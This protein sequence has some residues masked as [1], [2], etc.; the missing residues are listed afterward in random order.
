MGYIIRQKLQQKFGLQQIFMVD[1]I[2]VDAVIGENKRTL[3]H[4]IFQVE[5]IYRRFEMIDKK[6]NPFNLTMYSL[7]LVSIKIG[8]LYISVSVYV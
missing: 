2:P 4:Y 3:L 1:E 6:I 7:L 5:H 8:T